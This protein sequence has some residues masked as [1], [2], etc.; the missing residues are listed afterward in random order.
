M[1]RSYEKINLKP[2]NFFFYKEMK[3][4]SKREREKEK[5]HGLIFKDKI[6]KK[7]QTVNI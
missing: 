1:R 7:K 6:N 3:N 5:R 4:E 2:F